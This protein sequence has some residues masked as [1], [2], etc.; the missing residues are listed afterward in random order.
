MLDREKAEISSSPKGYEELK[1]VHGVYISNT[2]IVICGI[3]ESEEHN[4]D[5]MGCSSVW[6]VIFRAP[7]K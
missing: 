7:I 5:E 3:P 6:H 1:N 2:E 4:C